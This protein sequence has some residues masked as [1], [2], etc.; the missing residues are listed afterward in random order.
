MPVSER[1]KKRFIQD[2]LI[3]GSNLT[4]RM[5]WDQGSNRVLIRDS[6]AE[7]NKLISKNVTYTMNTVGNGSAQQYTS[8]IYLLDLLDMQNNVRTV[9]GYGNSSIMESSRPSS[10][11]IKHLFPHLPDAAFK[12]LEQNQVDVLIGLNMAKSKTER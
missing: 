6:F 7:A 3:R 4:A 11:P 10:S 9:W 5:F 1:M 12:S 8:K 2:I